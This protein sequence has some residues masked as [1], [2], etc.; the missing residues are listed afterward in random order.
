MTERKKRILQAVTDDYISTA[1][2]VGSRTIA[3]RYNLGISPATIRNEM[4][5]LEENGY[6]EQ[7]HASAGRI[8][9]DKGYRFYVDMIMMTKDLSPREKTGIK[10]ELEKRRREI[11]GLM[12]YTAR[13]MAD[14]T[15]YTAL[16][17]CP[18]LKNNIVKHLE[19]IPLGEADALVVLV[20]SPGFVETRVVDLPTP[21]SK[22]DLAQVGRY[23]NERLKGL[24][25][26]S[27]KTSLLRE[28]QRELKR[29]SNILEGAMELLVRSLEAD[30]RERVYLEGTV[31]LLEH[32]EFKE[33]EKAKPVL[34]IL[35]E[36]GTLFEALVDI[37][38]RG[39]VKAVIG[40]ENPQEEMKR[41]SLVGASYEVHGRIAGG[42][43]LLGPTR[44]DYSR[45]MALVGFMAECLSEILTEMDSR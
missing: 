45:A 33:I 18:R 37:L 28:M 24:T 32:P 35:S 14:L 26:G 7:P 36:G 8:P 44:M 9:S 12:Q 2:P 29:Y 34:N 6:L 11:E 15:Q 30:Y 25:I 20:M 5:D 13:I 22:E 31:N 41:C 40:R 17:F 27:I 16:I 23:L 3:R 42:L 21:V 1:E 10:R 38:N 43:G 4:A 39:G 19:L